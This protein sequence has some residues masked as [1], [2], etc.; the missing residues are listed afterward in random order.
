MTATDK[1]SSPPVPQPGTLATDA[2][3]GTTGAAA[4]VAGSTGKPGHSFAD[5]EDEWRHAP[6][7]PKD[8]GVLDSLGRSIS[9]AV[10]GADESVA[11][12]KPDGSR[13]G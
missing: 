11:K 13:K 5:E 4:P 6:V 9:E 1:T 3:A 10:I 7:A 2:G 8:S 12:P